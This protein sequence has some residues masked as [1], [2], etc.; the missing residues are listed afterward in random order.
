M[1]LQEEDMQSL[2]LATDYAAPLEQRI[3][4]L[5][6]CYSRSRGMHGFLLCIKSWI[7]PAGAGCLPAHGRVAFLGIKCFRLRSYCVP[8]DMPETNYYSS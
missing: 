3:H 7:T 5:S 2:L 1:N 6:A 8:E 4:F